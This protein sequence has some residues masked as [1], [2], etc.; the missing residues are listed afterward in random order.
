MT[1]ALA[2]TTGSDEIIV[3]DTGKGIDPAFLPHVF[4][5]FRQ[6][7]ASTTRD[8]GGLGL[9]LAIVRQLAELHGG[10]VRA[11]SLGVDRGSRFIVVLPAQQTAPGAAPDSGR[12]APP[13]PPPDLPISR[14][15]A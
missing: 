15:C 7:D 9:G 1:A 8:H 10:T 3:S 4:A 12:H 14:A 11:E 13:A 6:A 2:R 5:P